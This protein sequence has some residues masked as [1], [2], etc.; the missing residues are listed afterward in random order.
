LIIEGTDSQATGAAG[1]F[2]TNE[3]SLRTLEGKFPSGRI[4]YFEALMRTS[5]LNGVPLHGEVIALRMYA[6]H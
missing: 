4:P 3:E 2:V 1:D 6:D 5:E